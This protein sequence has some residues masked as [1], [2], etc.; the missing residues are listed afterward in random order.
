MGPGEH[1]F[2]PETFL[3]PALGELVKRGLMVPGLLARSL[4]DYISNFPRRTLFDS[5]FQL[6]RALPVAVFLSGAVLLGVEIAATRVLAPF[7]GNSLFVWGALFSVVYY[8]ITRN[9]S[10][11][12][13][14]G[15]L[16]VSHWVLDLIVHINE[17]GVGQGVDRGGLSV[18]GK[19]QAAALV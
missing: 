15:A 12:W 11:A 7:F 2:T 1:P 17:E 13:L 3:T 18:P 8:L 19:D 6:S 9:R 10:G 14:L 16:V 5:L 4:G